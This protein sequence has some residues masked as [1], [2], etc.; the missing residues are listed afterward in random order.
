LGFREKCVESPDRDFEI[1]W[2]GKSVMVLLEFTHEWG[3]G[4]SRRLSLDAL[5]GVIG[6]LQV[7][8]AVA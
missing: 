7:F 4:L 5:Y 1:S 2:F 6:Q 3:N 8:K